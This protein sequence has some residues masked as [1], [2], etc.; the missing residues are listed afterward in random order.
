MHHHRIPLRSGHLQYACISAIR[1]TGCRCVTPSGHYAVGNCPCS[2]LP[3]CLVIHVCCCWPLM[4]LLRRASCS[5]IAHS[6]RIGAAHDPPCCSRAPASTFAHVVSPSTHGLY[7]AVRLSL[8][9]FELHSRASTCNQHGFFK[10]LLVLP[11]T[12]SL[13]SSSSSP[14]QHHCLF[15]NYF[16]Y[17]DNRGLHYTF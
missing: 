6:G 17:S 4:S 13:P 16:F 2:R 8:A 14:S 3:T 12:P 10:L 1:A 11:T 15:P 7:H 5:Y 9:Y